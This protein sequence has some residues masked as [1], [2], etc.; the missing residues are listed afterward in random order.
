[1]FCEKNPQDSTDVPSFIAG[2]EGA[3]L[4]TLLVGTKVRNPESSGEAPEGAIRSGGVG[5]GERDGNSNVP[6]VGDT[7]VDSGAS[8]D[9]PLL[10]EGDVGARVV[11]VPVGLV[12]IEGN[13]VGWNVWDG[14]VG[15]TGETGRAVG[16]DIGCGVGRGV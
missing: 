11:I 12:G 6:M 2:K 10:I 9:A 5:M 7:V 15:E 1:M 4:S 8:V 3:L 13:I 16:G 14:E